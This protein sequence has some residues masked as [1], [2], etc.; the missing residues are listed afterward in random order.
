MLNTY[1][2]EAVKLLVEQEGRVTTEIEEFESK[3]V[4]VIVENPVEVM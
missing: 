3:K 1:R 2:G 4:R